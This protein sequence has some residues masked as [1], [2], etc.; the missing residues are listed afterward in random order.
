[1]AASLINLTPMLILFL[2]AQR[3]FVKGIVVSGM[4]GR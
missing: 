3:F 4:G 1:M 2:V